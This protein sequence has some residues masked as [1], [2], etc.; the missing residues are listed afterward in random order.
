MKKLNRFIRDFG[1][2]ILFIIGVLTFVFS[3]IY[4]PFKEETPINIVKPA[5]PLVAPVVDICTGDNAVSIA[6]TTGHKAGPIPTF[7]LNI[8]NRNSVSKEVKMKFRIYR[9]WFV[10]FGNNKTASFVLPVPYGDSSQLIVNADLLRN[11]E[12]IRRWIKVKDVYLGSRELKSIF[13]ASI[14][15]VVDEND[16]LYNLFNVHKFKLANNSRRD[17]TMKEVPVNDKEHE[18]IKSFLTEYN[19]KLLP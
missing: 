5:P 13:V 3:F 16:S 9:E 6:E 8:C 2:L 7:L 11:G 1:L 17:H 10:D 15:S 18:Q 12:I 4:N 19:P 14:G